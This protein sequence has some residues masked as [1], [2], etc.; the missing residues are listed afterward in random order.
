M[1][2]QRGRTT[3]SHHQNSI[4]PNLLER[5]LDQAAPSRAW[6]NDVNFA[7]SSWAT[8]H[9]R[10]T[11]SCPRRWR[12]KSRARARPAR[13]ATYDVDVDLRRARDI[14]Q[15]MAS[16][17]RRSSINQPK[18]ARRNVVSQFGALPVLKSRRALDPAGLVRNGARREALFTPM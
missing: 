18:V 4:E 2:A 17:I 11:S 9:F 1:G 12:A 16:S 5:Q 7:T 3:G 15:R 13:R 14:E 8:E 10:P 6:V